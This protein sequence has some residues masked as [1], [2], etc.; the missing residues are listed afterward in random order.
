MKACADCNSA[1]MSKQ[2]RSHPALPVL[3]DA[4]HCRAWSAPPGERA[5]CQPPA[6]ALWTRRLDS[7]FLH[8]RWGV[9]VFAA[10][11]LFVFQAIFSW[12]RPL[13]EAAQR[14][15]DWS[16][17]RLG[18][19][20]PGA[21]LRSLIVDGI[22]RGVGSVVV[23]LP[24][25]LL[26]FAFLGILED[27]GYLAR[28]ARIADRAMSRV[29]LQ[30]VSFMPLLSAHACAT[31]AILAARTIG[32]R[33]DRMAT[34]LVAPLMSCSARLP[35]Y[36]L[37]V[38]AFVPERALVGPLLGTRAAT[39]LGLYLLGFLAAFGTARL[40]K[41]S[42]LKSDPAPC[43]AELPP[44]RWP[45]L[46]GLAA[47]LLEA[48]KVFLRRAGGVVLAVAVVMWVLAHLPVKDGQQQPPIEHS[49]AGGLG[50]LLEPAVKPLGFNW[51]ISAGLVSSL[52][53]RE[54]II[55]TLGT[56]HRLDP[57]TQSLGLQE[58]LRTDLTPSGA[59]ALL[60]L[61]A[62]SMPCLTTVGVVYRETGSWKWPLLQSAYMGTLAYGG[63]FLANRLVGLLA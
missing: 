63:A 33:R 24:Q 18:A 5:P 25:I 38:A 54:A 41:S 7:L 60:V 27:S 16:G 30:G 12:G 10:V 47:R 11:V 58:A 62:L 57:A 28:A 48:A 56:I 42:I 45:A 15:I 43:V 26:L 34:I 50:R 8:P 6:P 13:T 35:V 39:I 2:A 17:T 40:L 20:V 37:V 32:S 29:G 61:F 52:A 59:A 9:W 46:R 1:A 55:G 49:L 23:F 21:L 19:L 53:A 44:Y 36:T 3:E 31:A 22:W 4:P 51:A 14:L